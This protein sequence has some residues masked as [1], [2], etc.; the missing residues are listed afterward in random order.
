MMLRLSPSGSTCR[1]MAFVSW[2]TA[3]ID[4]HRPKLERVRVACERRAASA[5]G[6]AG[7]AVSGVS[8]GRRHRRAHPATGRPSP[9]SASTHRSH[10]PSVAGA[11]D[12]DGTMRQHRGHLSPSARV[13]GDLHVRTR[14]RSARSRST[15]ETMNSIGRSSRY[16]SSS[17]AVVA[18]RAQRDL[19]RRA[20]CR[21]SWPAAPPRARGSPRRGSACSRS[22]RSTS[23]GIDQRRPTSRGNSAR[24]TDSSR[25][26]GR[27]RHSSSVVIGRIGA[28]SRVR[29]SAMMYMAVCAERRSG[30]AGRERVEPVLRHVGVERA[31]IDRREL[32]D[33]L[34]DRR[35]VVGLVRA[36]HGRGRR[37][38]T[39]R[40]RTGRPPASDRAGRD[41]PPDRSRTGSTPDTAAC[42]GSCGRPRSTR[43]RI[44]L[45][46][47][48]SSR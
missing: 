9:C 36:Q 28:S 21:S 38:R 2:S 45:P 31:Q 27:W 18:A 7:A 16:R 3:T 44:C 20:S 42:C 41:R 46:T 14:R 29:P 17:A 40:A 22:Q 12:T 6:A 26:P 47:R 37:R 24:W 8:G 30:D 43:A 48:T 32:V 13:D 15:C 5:G 11:D 39:A 35:E 19:A 4:R 33:G 1:T 25:V 34:E 10:S 23:A